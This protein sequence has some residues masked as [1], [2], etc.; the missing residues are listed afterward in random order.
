MFKYHRRRHTEREISSA[1]LV[2]IAGIDGS[3]GGG[4]GDGGRVEL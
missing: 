3:D 2:H 4:G 1:L